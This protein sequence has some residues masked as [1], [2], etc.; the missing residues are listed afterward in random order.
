MYDTCVTL[1]AV[2]RA[3]QQRVQH[4]YVAHPEDDILCCHDSVHLWQKRRA[5]IRRRSGGA[6]LWGLK[7]CAYKAVCS[8]AQLWLV[9]AC[10]QRP[11]VVAAVAVQAAAAG[12]TD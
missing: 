1:S 8:M 6:A 4:F 10:H 3:S 2:H 12:P 7:L 9:A 11:G 5:S